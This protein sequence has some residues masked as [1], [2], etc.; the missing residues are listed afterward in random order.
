MQDH[1]NRKADKIWNKVIEP[2]LSNTRFPIHG[3]EK[4]FISSNEALKY[5]LLGQV[6]LNNGYKLCVEDVLASFV[7]F[8]PQQFRQIRAY[9][10]SFLEVA[11]ELVEHVNRCAERSFLNLSLRSQKGIGC[12][13]S[14]QE[15]T[16]IFEDYTCAFKRY[17]SLFNEE[18]K[19]ATLR[20]F[21]PSEKGYVES[22]KKEYTL[23]IC[24][25]SENEALDGVFLLVNDYDIITPKGI[26][27]VH[28]VV[29]KGGKNYFSADSISA[30]I[31]KHG[32]HIWA[33]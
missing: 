24:L 28:N 15:V 4:F 19:V 21:F 8:F 12:N 17:F 3:F 11:C 18:G 16:A 14:V 30:K 7:V 25:S 33:S 5:G 2:F 1:R 6:A 20:V 9:Q 31:P 13:Y 10:G 23:D 32:M 29:A 26:S 22:N 27:H